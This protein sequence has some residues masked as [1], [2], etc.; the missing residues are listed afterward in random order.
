MSAKN[1]EIVFP[2]IL[3]E[4]G[5][6][7][8]D[9]NDPGGA[10]NL[11]VTKAS[12]EAYV[13]HPVTVQDMKDLEP[14]I[15]KPFYKKMYWD[16]CRCDELPSGVDYAVMDLAVNSGPGRAAQMLQ[17][18]VSVEADGK[19]GP[20]TLNAVQMMM[21]RLIIERVCNERLGF[22]ENLSTF[23]YYGRGWT[24]RV[25]RVRATALKMLTQ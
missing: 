23:R 24:A 19:I 13:G 20:I 6:F 25:E 15:V 2:L 1:W 21:P 22:L 16:K 3:R 10:T 18:A 11:G 17:H 5:G 12:W 9:K 7:N 4:E 8:N 14:F